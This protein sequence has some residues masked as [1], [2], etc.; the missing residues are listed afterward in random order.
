M[1]MISK[2]VKLNYFICSV[3]I[4]YNVREGETKLESVKDGFKILSTFYCNLFWS[5]PQKQF[6]S[7]E[8][9][10]LR[11]KVDEQETSDLLA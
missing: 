2:L 4:T 9:I 10:F 3:P 5:P 6:S 11:K 8:N 7:K 1:E